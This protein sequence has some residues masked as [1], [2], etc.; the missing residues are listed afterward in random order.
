[1]ASKSPDAGGD[2]ITKVYLARPSWTQSSDFQDLRA[3]IENGGKREIVEPSVGGARDAKPVGAE[4][5]PQLEGYQP[6]ASMPFGD[7]GGISNCHALVAIIDDKGIDPVVAG[8]IG[9]AHGI[10][11]QVIA[12][13]PNFTRDD[14]PKIYRIVGYFLDYTICG[15]PDEVSRR[16]DARKDE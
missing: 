2:T 13:K 11:R 6:S 10:C 16:L 15:N 14:I 3:A 5:A 7:P 9:F 4:P 8:A 12:Y 1:M